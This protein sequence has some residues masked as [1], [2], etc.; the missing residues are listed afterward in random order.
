MEQP[1][2]ISTKTATKSKREKDG[3]RSSI[4]DNTKMLRVNRD[5]NVV[6]GDDIEI[7]FQHIS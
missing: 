1:T 6:R 3:M 4:G 5:E 2:Q 7:G